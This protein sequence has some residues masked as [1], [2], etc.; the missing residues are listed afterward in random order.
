MSQRNLRHFRIFLA[1]ADLG[2]PT[3]AAERC[4]LSQPAVTQALRRMEVQAGGALFTRGR[5]GFFLTERGAVFAVRVRRAMTRLDAALAEVSGDLV[6]SASRAQLQAV[7][8]LCEAQNFTLAA[9]SLGLAQPT[10]H[11]AVGQFEKQAGR[12]LFERRPAGVVP[13]RACRRLADAARLAFA[14][15]DQADAEI[16]QFDGRDAGRIVVGAL[17]LSRSVVLPRA[18]ARF[19]AERPG[20]LV[21]VVDG[22]YDEM[23]AGLRR[24]DVDVIVGA[25]R[26]PAPVADIVQEGLFDD[27]LAVLARPGHPLAGTESL[28]ARLLA[29]KGWIVP[30]PGTP[31]RVQF[32][33]FFDRHDLPTPESIVECG[34]ILLMR[35]L[36]LRS[37][38]LGCISD[39]QAEAEVAYGLLVSLQTGIDWPARR[40]GLSYRAD[41]TPTRAQAALLEHIRAASGGTTA[42]TGARAETGRHTGPRPA[43]SEAR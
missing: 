12:Q 24:G 19:R 23:L 37:D 2:T 10:V 33:A 17:P 40:I 16:A 32:E 28:S 21:T 34:S 41:W 29:S 15:L 4:N 27:R 7:L 3:R 1:V 36:L 31:S 42:A 43:T 30:G 11:R 22:R 9:R 35:E 39:Q 38:L 26:D 18:L 6:T 14:E 8:A 20:Q 5:G 13:T 25:L